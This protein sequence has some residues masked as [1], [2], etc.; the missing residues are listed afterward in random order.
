MLVI[1]Q[2]LHS[3]MG[4]AA[5]VTDSTDTDYFRHSGKFYRAMVFQMF[6]EM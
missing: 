1:F 3:Y 4:L 6:L 5:T 2:V